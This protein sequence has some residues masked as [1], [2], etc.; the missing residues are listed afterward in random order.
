MTQ[1]IPV[2]VSTLRLKYPTMSFNEVEV[3]QVVANNHK[4]AQRRE[5]RRLS[6]KVQE[7]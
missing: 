1:K 5:L 4:A 3:P 2:I 6:H 7:L